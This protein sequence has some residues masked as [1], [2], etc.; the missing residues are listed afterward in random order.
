MGRGEYT[1]SC[2]INMNTICKKDSLKLI[3]PLFIFPKVQYKRMVE[4]SRLSY[5]VL[6]PALE[7]VEELELVEDSCQQQ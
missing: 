2:L 6:S 4:I 5:K 1:P 7:L 3:F